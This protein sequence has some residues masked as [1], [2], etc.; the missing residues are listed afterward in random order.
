MMLSYLN[1]SLFASGPGDYSRNPRGFVG[2]VSASPLLPGKGN[3]SVQD[4]DG[5]TPTDEPQ[6]LTHAD[7]RHLRGDFLKINGIRRRGDGAPAPRNHHPFEPIGERILPLTGRLAIR[8][9]RLS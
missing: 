7:N 8:W 4:R 6:G 2:R 9:W 1:I 3:A 5:G